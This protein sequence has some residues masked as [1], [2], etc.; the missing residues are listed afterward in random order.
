[1]ETHRRT[2][3]LQ[4]LLCTAALRHLALCAKLRTAAGCRQARPHLHA[5][6]REDAVARHVVEPVHDG[7][8]FGPVHAHA[9]AGPPEEQVPFAVCGH[10]WGR[11]K[12]VRALGISRRQWHKQ[13]GPALPQTCALAAG[14]AVPR[15]A[16]WTGLQLRILST[17]AGQLV[18]SRRHCTSRQKAAAAGTAGVLINGVVVRRAQ[19][20]AAHVSAAGGA[21]AR[22][23]RSAALRPARRDRT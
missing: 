14:A 19:R 8:L 18:S 15:C 11:G 20:S 1:M 9:H 7:A 5:R 6:P 2:E 13:H 12:R 23:V 17:P 21:R 4:K 10:T 3:K 22:H 16:L